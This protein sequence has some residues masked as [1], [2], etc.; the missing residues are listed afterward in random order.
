MALTKV[1]SSNITLTTPAASSND[2]SPATTAYVT[3]ALANLVDSAPGTLNTLNELAAALGDDAN[4]STTVT[5]SIATKLPLAGGTMTGNLGVGDTAVS[6]ITGLFSTS[7]ANHIAA[8]FVNSNASDS[9]GIVVKAGND[10]NDYTADFRDKD[11]N[12][13]MRIRGDGN[14]GIGTTSP[15]HLLEL[16]RSSTDFG[17]TLEINNTSSANGSVSA[18]RYVTENETTGLMIG[19]HS[20]GFTGGADLAF[21]NQELN[22][23]LAISTNNTE[24]M[25][26]SS[27]GKVIIGDT[28]SHTDDL[29]QIETPA[30]GGGH[31]IQIRRN[32][33]NGDQGIGRVMFGNNNDTDLATI[34]SV[35]DGQADCARL[36]FSTQPT[37]GSSTERMSID[38]S[39]YVKIGNTSGPGI[40]NVG[41]GSSDGG[42]VHFANN[43]GATTLTNDQGL[44]F[45]W[46]KSNAQGESVIIANQGPGSVGGLVFATNTSAG[47]YNERMRIDADGNLLLGTTTRLN[48]SN[49][50]AK[51]TD[52]VPLN[53]RRNNGASDN[54]IL[55]CYKSTSTAVL[56]I[57]GDG[58]VENTNGSY[59]PLSSDERLK[60]NIVD[61]S[62]QWEDV[63]NIKLKNFTYKNDSSGLVQMGPIAQELEKVSPN[64]IKRREASPQDIE[65]S[66]GLIKEGDEVLTYKS[67]VMKL[68]AFVA[69]QEAMTKIEEQQVIIEDLKSRIETLEG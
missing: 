2:T 59:G 46:N 23:D 32:D 39:G 15:A 44:A 52:H 31:G 68:K 7:T 66:G 67:S 9:F 57:R 33:S 61:V 6:S 3:T 14:V 47:S 5:N 21:I 18:V 26:I 35:T 12:N 24:R 28:A 13:H 45:G 1:K 8:Q 30:S 17:A 62:S 20:N 56:S 65:N 19:K 58:D 41:N 50:I 36:V 48:N 25:R 40:L 22:S 54:S 42:Y 16:V 27:G 38:S 34:S 37:S 49:T 10:A 11:N 55:L 43:V 60:E 29:F 51:T 69:L 64:L 4:F 63:K 53:I